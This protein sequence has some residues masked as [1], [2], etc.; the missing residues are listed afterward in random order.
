[1][2]TVGGPEAWLDERR[3]HVATWIAEHIR[4]AARGPDETLENGG[5]P[6]EIEIR[7]YQL[8]AW[9]SLWDAREAGEKR[10]LLHLATGL[11]KTFV[12]ICDVLK[13]RQ[14]WTETNQGAVPPSALFVSHKN[15]INE[16]A[17]HDFLSVM[18]ELTIDVFETQREDP[19]AHTDVRFAT[20]QAILSEQDKFNPKDYGYIIYDEA[21]HT[22][23][24]TFGAVRSHFRPLFELALTATPKRMD[25]QDITHYF[26]QPVYSKDLPEAMAEGL[27]ADVDYRIMLDDAVRLVIESGFKPKTLQDM[28]SLIR[29]TPRN[30]KIAEHIREEQQN[31]GDA[32][33]A[34]VFCYDIEHVNAMAQELGA[35]AYHSGKSKKVRRQILRDF[36]AGNIRTICTRDMFNEGVNIPDAT[37][38]VFARTTASETVYLQQL[39]RGLRGRGKTVTVLDFVANIERIVKLKELSEAVRGHAQ[40]LGQQTTNSGSNEAGG[41]MRIHTDHADFTFDRLVIDIA[42]KFLEL[43]NRSLPE[44][45]LSVTAAGNELAISYATLLTWASILELDLPVFEVRADGSGLRGVSP[46]NLQRLREYRDALLTT[47][48][49]ILS[50]KAWHGRLDLSEKT[51]VHLVGKMGW[52][53]LPYRLTTNGAGSARALSTSQINQLKAHFPETF[54]PLVPEGWQTIRQFAEELGID[55]GTVERARDRLG[56]PPTSHKTPGGQ[57]AQTLSPEQIETLR[58]LPEF[59]IT[60]ADDTIVS[61]S[62]A[63]SELNSSSRRILELVEQHGI[64]LS[65]YAFGRSARVGKGMTPEQIEFIRPLLHSPL[66]DGYL[67]PTQVAGLLGMSAR[68]LRRRVEELGWDVPWFGA[69]KGSLGKPGRAFSPEQVELLKTMRGDGRL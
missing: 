24:E 23:A 21:H 25:E 2:E 44:G 38:L 34:I 54:M 52:V 55:G 18:P 30:E 8:D 28:Y 15:E 4:P 13:F 66:P 50:I 10:A 53:P 58:Q 41:G 64:E 19:P 16:Q 69:K 48:E 5:Q 56:W 43:Q 59:N 63:A 29:V 27:L 17:A 7:G 47:D 1:M 35:V 33:K 49:E 26:G 36:R 12:A 60:P 20:F 68:T 22:E 6:H 65:V 31:Q 3:A 14:E 62:Q 45:W 42:A 39:G 57:V 40:T 46:E 37:L 61:V 11:G 32:A 67:R 9:G 51:L